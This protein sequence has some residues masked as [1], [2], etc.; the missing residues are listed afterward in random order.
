MSGKKNTRALLKKK[1]KPAVAFMCLLSTHKV[2]NL[3]HVLI[4]MNEIQRRIRSPDVK[5]KYFHTVSIESFFVSSSSR[6]GIGFENGEMFSR[7]TL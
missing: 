6:I 3:N 4:G 5:A 1:S 2:R 7:D